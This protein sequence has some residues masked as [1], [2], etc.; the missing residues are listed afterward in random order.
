MAGKTKIEWTAK[1]GRP[2]RTWNPVAG[3]ALAS[4]GCSN[5]Y[6]MRQAHRIQLMQAGQGK[7][8]H[9]EGTTKVVNGNPVWTG[10]ATVAPDSVFLA[11][12]RWKKP[13]TIFVNSMSDLFYERFSD[14]VID[15]VFAVAAL[16]P[17]HVLQILTKRSGRMFAYMSDKD[18][19][20]KVADAVPFGLPV[21]FFKWPL[22]NC[23]M[24]VSA[25]DQ[26]RYDERKYHLRATPAAVRFFSFEPLLG[27]IEADYLADWAIVGAESGP[28]ARPMQQEWVK[29]IKD[30]CVDTGVPFFLK[31]RLGED[32]RKI[33]MPFLD[34]QVWDQMP[35]TRP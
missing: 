7:T 1:D 18:R 32:G 13:T 5:C 16:C 14:E 35:G 33:S 6:A 8:S 31:Q 21:P 34:G 20:K 17:Q 10:K 11:P 4:A 25:E 23:W 27:P 15:R 12:L 29:S 9:Y 26:R 24:G 30:Q 28:G 2:G 22:P 3:C 19:H